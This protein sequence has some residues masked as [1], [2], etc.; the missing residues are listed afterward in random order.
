MNPCN[1]TG[2]RWYRQKSW[3]RLK[4]MLSGEN[5]TPT[6]PNRKHCLKFWRR[7][8]VSVTRSP[9]NRGCC[10]RWSVWYK[11]LQISKSHLLCFSVISLEFGFLTSDRTGGW[12]WEVGWGIFYLT[13]VVWPTRGAAV[14]WGVRAAWATSDYVHRSW[15]PRKPDQS[16]DQTPGFK[17]RARSWGV[18]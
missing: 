5:V 4:R 6:V 13:P 10:H 11:K 18:I 14:V 16:T 15:K 7:G 2:N 17:E 3:G 1:K 12:S 9:W 8:L